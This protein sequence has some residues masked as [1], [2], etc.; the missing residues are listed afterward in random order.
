M[1][2]ESLEGVGKESEVVV[3][4]TY[5]STKYICTSDLRTWMHPEGS[6][7]KVGERV[8]PP[9]ELMKPDGREV[10]A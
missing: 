4:T 5:Q 2:M 3:E 10:G 9:S 1:E 6:K 8:R 7:V